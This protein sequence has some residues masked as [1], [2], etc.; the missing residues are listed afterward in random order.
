MNLYTPKNRS[1]VYWDMTASTLSVF[2]R[3]IQ[4]VWDFFGGGKGWGEGEGEWYMGGCFWDQ[5]C[6]KIVGTLQVIKVVSI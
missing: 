2:V 1:T 6:G 3:N 5:G 4:W